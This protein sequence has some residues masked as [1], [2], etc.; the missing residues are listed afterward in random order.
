MAIKPYEVEGQ[1]FYKVYV[2][3]RCRENPGLRV[4]RKLRSIK[5]EREA[6]REE[7]RL[8][9]ECERELAEKK[10]RGKTWCEIVDAWE[11]YLTKTGINDTTRIDYVAAIRKHTKDWLSRA[12][13]E[14]T[15]LEVRQLLERLKGE[16]VSQSYLCKIKIIIG[17][18]FIFGLEQ[19]LIPEGRNPTFGIKLRRAEEKKPEVLTF[20]QIRI[21]LDEAKRLDYAWYPVW[22]VA[23]L[24]GMRNG[25]LYALEWSDINWD[26][27]IISVNKSYNCRKRVIKST[28]SG[29]WRTVPISAPL[30]DLLKELQ[31][32]AGDRKEVLPRLQGWSKGEQANKLR[33]FCVGIG[34]PSVKF[35]TLRACF[36]TQLIR[37]GVAPIQIQKICGWKDLETMQRY[38]RLAG[39]ETDG[40]T[41]VLNIL[42][43]E[44]ALGYASEL[45]PNAL[46][47]SR[48]P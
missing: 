2:N 28:K 12:A 15:Q 18:A 34:L 30:L 25:E 14:V 33:M 35:H 10:N 24:T 21:L 9:R 45:A 32:K 26:S 27:K 17:R 7:I 16:G 29:C 42:P 40:V 6:Q 36:A 23:L 22:A 5:T 20:N 38:V 43:S 48:L 44:Q 47:S 41:E 13:K 1:I 19:G 4:Q 37:K 39:I 8:I 46:A 31:A 11:M 3:L